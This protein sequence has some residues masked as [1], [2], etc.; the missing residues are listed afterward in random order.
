[1]EKGVEGDRGGRREDGERRRELKETGEEGGRSR[2][3]EEKREWKDRK[4]KEVEIE[5]R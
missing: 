2:V 3:R 5:E 4:E 1:M